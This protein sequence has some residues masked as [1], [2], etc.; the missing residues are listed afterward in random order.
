MR[1]ARAF[2]LTAV[3]LAVVGLLI[4]PVLGQSGKFLDNS[5][6]FGHAQAPGLAGRAEFMIHVIMAGRSGNTIWADPI[7]IC[8]SGRGG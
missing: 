8:G 5:Q 6:P 7:H 1:T 4:V 3:L 2:V